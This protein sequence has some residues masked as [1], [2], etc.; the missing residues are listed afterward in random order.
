MKKLMGF[1]QMQVQKEIARRQDNAVEKANI[2]MHKLK[3][4]YTKFVDANPDLFRDDQ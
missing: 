2:L 3:M 1:N 4:D